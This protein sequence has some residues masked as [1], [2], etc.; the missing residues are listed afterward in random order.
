MQTFI[1]TVPFQH[2][3]WLFLSRTSKLMGN[4]K[5]DFLLLNKLR[6]WLFLM[7]E[8]FVVFWG[9]IVYNMFFYNI[10]DMFFKIQFWIN[11]IYQVISSSVTDEIDLVV[12][13]QICNACEPLFSRIMNWNLSGF[14]FIELYTNHS[15]T[16]YIPCIRLVNMISTFIPQEQ[17]L[18]S[19]AK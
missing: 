6:F 19:S 18:L 1:F 17:K 16:F 12:I 7:L 15:Y 4:R 10:I 13:S 5:I 8:L 3:V 9:H 14:A 11:S 2:F